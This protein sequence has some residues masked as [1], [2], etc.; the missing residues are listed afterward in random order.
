LDIE[1]KQMPFYAYIDRTQGPPYSIKG[2]LDTDA[3]TYS[4]MP[5][6]DD[7]IEVSKD[8]WDRHIRDGGTWGADDNRT[9]RQLKPMP[10][11]G[12]VEAEA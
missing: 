9:V 7:L 12:P 5:S 4:N 6:S 11:L 2:W 8:I 10:K 3:L 1:E